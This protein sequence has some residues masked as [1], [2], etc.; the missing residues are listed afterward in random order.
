MKPVEIATNVLERLDDLF[1]YIV[2]EYKAPET[3]HNYI[4]KVNDF[5]QKLG[6]CFV[7][8]KCRRKKWY[9]KGY[10]C[11]IFDHRWVFAYQIYDDRVIIH[12]MDYAAN[13]TDIDL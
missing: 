5:L 4:E 9:V 11:A 7:L 10:H 8:A 13:I 12:D 1:N 2:N 3:A 6:G